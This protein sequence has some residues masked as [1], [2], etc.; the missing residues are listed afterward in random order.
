MGKHADVLGEEA[1]EWGLGGAEGWEDYI[2]NYKEK[3]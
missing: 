2:K 3:G 1:G